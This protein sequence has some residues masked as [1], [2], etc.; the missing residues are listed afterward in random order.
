MLRAAIR[1]AVNH[2]VTGARPVLRHL[3]LRTVSG[4][5]P[6]M[7]VDWAARVASVATACGL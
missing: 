3:A 6:L 2:A 1:S 7:V 5:L 4:K